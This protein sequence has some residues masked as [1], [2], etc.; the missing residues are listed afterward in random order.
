M[1]ACSKQ[2][3]TEGSADHTVEHAFVDDCPLRAANA[4]SKSASA[5]RSSGSDSS[6]D[7]TS[8]GFCCKAL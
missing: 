3:A 1:G 8:A 2:K 5:H 6:T 4:W 7:C